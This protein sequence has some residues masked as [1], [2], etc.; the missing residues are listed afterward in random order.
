MRICP[1]SCLHILRQGQA[2][3][4]TIRPPLSK[5]RS[6]SKV[7][8]SR[9][10]LLGMMDPKLSRAVGVVVGISLGRDPSDVRFLDK[11]VPAL[12]FAEVD[13]VFRS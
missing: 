13:R 6:K 11:V 9:A 5:P 12:L 2:R 4:H 7:G 8:S 10:H 1:L 3:L